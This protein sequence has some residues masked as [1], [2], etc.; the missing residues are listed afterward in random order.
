MNA[1]LVTAYVPIPGHP[2][3]AQ[4]YGA[5]GEKLGGVPVRKKCFYNTPNQLWLT[6]YVAKLPFKPSISRGDNPAKNTL[7]YHA[8]NHQKSTWLVEAAKAYPDADWLCWVDYG[9]FHQE[10]INNQVIYEMFEKLEK[11]PNDKIY[12]PGCWDKP[13][14]VEASYPCWRFCGSVIAVPRKLVDAFDYGCRVAARKH[15]SST[16][17]IEFEVNT[18]ARVE[19]TGKLPFHIYRADHNATLFTEFPDAVQ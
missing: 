10:G 5:L 19:H 2:R 12:A 15:I 6:K 7:L 4:E 11:T 14:A 13:L 16:K 8:V 9:V 3:S 17:N 18:Y 1:R